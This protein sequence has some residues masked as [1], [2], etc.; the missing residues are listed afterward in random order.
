MVGLGAAP[1]IF[2]LCLMHLLPETPRYLLLRDRVDEAESILRKIYPFATVEQ[3]A[4]KAK[5]IGTSVKLS[6]GNSNL[7]ATWKRLHFD[8]AN[9]RGLVIAC[10]LQGIQQLC[11]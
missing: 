7:I 2:Q 3:I 9:L 4:L 11:G 5:V 6:S 1:P 10:G 8:P